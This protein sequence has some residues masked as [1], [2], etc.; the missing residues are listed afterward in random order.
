MVSGARLRFGVPK[1]WAK[2]GSDWA[3]WADMSLCVLVRDM[4]AGSSGSGCRWVGVLGPVGGG[5][6]VGAGAAL[7]VLGVVEGVAAGGA[8]TR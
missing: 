3:E 7:V 4:E 5:W 2:E 8:E 6:G 1:V